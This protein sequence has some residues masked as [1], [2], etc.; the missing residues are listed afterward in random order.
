MIKKKKTVKFHKTMSEI[1]RFFFYFELYSECIDN[2]SDSCN[3]IILSLI[4]II[5]LCQ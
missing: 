1:L 5:F 3:Q 4:E 2:I